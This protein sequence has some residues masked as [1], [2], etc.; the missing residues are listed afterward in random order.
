M[1]KTANI[2]E[3]LNSRKVELA[4][5]KVEL[6][7][8]EVID[9]FKKEALADVA[10]VTKDFGAIK[11]QADKLNAVYKYWSAMAKMPDNKIK[12]ISAQVTQFEK[13]AKELG[14]DPKNQQAFKDAYEAIDRYSEVGDNLKAM[15]DVIAGIGKV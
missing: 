15:R 10:K 9:R 7:I 6:G 8:V 14:I 4:S 3:F 12:L 13:L 2:T 5:E 1:S 11:A